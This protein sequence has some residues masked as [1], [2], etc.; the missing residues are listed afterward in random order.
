VH[1]QGCLEQTVRLRV[2]VRNNMPAVPGRYP[3]KRVG[4][5]RILEHIVVG[6]S[7]LTE[8]SQAIG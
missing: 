1:A 4:T 3:R 6:A 5:P 8:P 7:L 2:P